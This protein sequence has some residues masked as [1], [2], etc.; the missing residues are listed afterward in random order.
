[1]ARKNNLRDIIDP[2]IKFSIM[3]SDGE[4]DGEHILAK[5]KGQ[6]FVPDGK[7]R[8]GRWYPRSLWEKITNDPTIKT[9]LKKRTMFGTVGHDAALNDKAI[10]EGLISHFMTDAY[11]DEGGQGIGEALI[12]NTPTGRILNTVLR[13][14]SE[15]FVSSRANGTFKGKKNGLPIVDEDNYDLD[16]WDFVIDPGFLEANP[17]IAES[18]NLLNNEEDDNIQDNNNNKE[19]NM[20]EELIKVVTTENANLKNTVS[21]LTDENGTLKEDNKTV[22]EENTHLKGEMTKLEEANTVI[23][24]Y[25]ELGTPEEIKEKFEKAD[26]DA[27]STAFIESVTDNGPE[28]IKTALETAKEFKTDIT[29]KFGTVEEITEAFDKADEFK[30]AVDEIGS[31]D[32][33]KEAMTSYSGLI[34]EQETDTKTKAIAGIVEDCKITEEKATELIEKYSEEDIRDLY[35]NVIEENNSDDSGRYTK[36]N[37]N[38]ENNND[39]DN[40]NNEQVSIVESSRIDRINK[41]LG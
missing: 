32:E 18:L 13:A 19:G 6:F 27:E 7:S 21:D 9:R 5:I 16:G 31:V 1:M 34:T 39:D 24:S 35:K 36:K 11:I 38:E 14:G 30:K 33:I 2:E 3:E 40:D 26:K 10:R 12:L 20:N 17:T 22:N 28:A 23:A 4:V 37:F 25:K 29:E 15:L 8:N 41:S